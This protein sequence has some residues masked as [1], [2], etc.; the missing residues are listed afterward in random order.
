[1]VREAVPSP[2]LPRR[3]GW[4]IP[5]GQRPPRR[6]SR[7][8]SPR[9][10]GGPARSPGPHTGESYE[11]VRRSSV[12]RGAPAPP[13]PASSPRAVTGG[14]PKAAPTRGSRNHPVEAGLARPAPV[15]NGPLR[16]DTI[17]PYKRS[18]KTP[19]SPAA[20]RLPDP[21]GYRRAATGRPYG[22]APEPIRRGGYHPPAWKAGGTD[23]RASLRTGSQ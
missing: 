20:S 8:P 3:P 17:R 1:M 6:I 5:G 10:R 13:R 23:C 19:R 21:D 15:L 18:R 12:G 11:Q 7:K 22:C 14:R 2:G 4:S 16:A 9:G